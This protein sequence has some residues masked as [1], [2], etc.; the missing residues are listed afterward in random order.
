M[1]TAVPL[2]QLRRKVT[3][4]EHVSIGDFEAAQFHL[5]RSEAGSQGSVYRKLHSF[6][7]SKAASA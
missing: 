4:L 2:D 6:P 1:K 3:E 7:F 5:Y